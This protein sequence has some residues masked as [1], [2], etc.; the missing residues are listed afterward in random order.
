M[1]MNDFLKSIEKNSFRESCVASLTKEN[2]ELRIFDGKGTLWGA[3]VRDVEPTRLTTGWLMMEDPL[4][5]FAGSGYKSTEVRDKT[6]ELQQEASKT[7]ALKG[8]RKLT[9]VKVAEALSS[10]KC[11]EEQTKVIAAV[12]YTLRNIQTV[13]FDE[14]KKSVWTYP[15][16]LRVWSKEKKTLWMD[17]KTEKYLDWSGKEIQFGLWLQERESEG[18]SVCW[19]ISDGLMEEM[20]A[21][22]ASEFPEMI[23]HA[24]DSKKVRKDDYARTLGRCEAIRNLV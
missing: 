3:I 9:K 4:M 22:M 15:E 12:L 17:A 24:A 2:K 7:G 10:L 1:K 6:F 8:N 11:T 23:V 18:W 5:I 21:K 14:E 13:C 19:P 20:K 16:D